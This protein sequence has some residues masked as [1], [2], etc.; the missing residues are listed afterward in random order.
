MNRT[1]CPTCGHEVRISPG[2]TEMEWDIEGKT[3]MRHGDFHLS[4]VC[5][6]CYPEYFRVAG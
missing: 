1:S 5:P 2:G 6:F 4:W 3:E